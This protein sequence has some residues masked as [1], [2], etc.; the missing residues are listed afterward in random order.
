MYMCMYV[1]MCVYMCIYIYVCACVCA[2][3][4]V[5]FDKILKF[6]NVAALGNGPKMDCLMDLRALCS[7]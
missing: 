2:C 6:Y 7:P 5:Y 4:C 1:Y 3:M